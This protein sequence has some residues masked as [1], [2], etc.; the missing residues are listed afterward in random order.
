MPRPAPNAPGRQSG[1]SAVIEAAWLYYHDGRN[2]NEIAG[3]LG[4]SRAT[5]VNYLQ[6]A[7]ERGLVRISL[8]SGAFTTHRLAAD[9][10]ARFG[11]S[12][13]Y[14]VP[15]TGLDTEA[16]FRRVVRG[17]AE[18]LP[19]L[20]AQGQRLG[21]AW[22][23]TMYELAEATARRPV[24][25]LTILQLVGSMATPYGFT[26]EACSTRLAGRL[27]ASCVNLHAPAILSNP[28][29]AAALRAEPIIAE[30]L[31]A[32]E[33]VDRFLFSVGT[34]TPDSHIVGSGVATLDELDWYVAR[35][36]TAVLCGRFI[37]DHG[38]AIP[39]PLDARMIGIEL[40]RMVRPELGLMATPGEDKIAPSRAAMRGG[41]VTHLV[42]SSAVAEALLAD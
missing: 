23:R 38:R 13:A 5:V 16:A 17:A 21:L 1:E 7:R 26:S 2:Q 12:A 39:G 9:L 28:E 8:D 40:S 30:Q 42:T 11:L 20:L 36:A 18:W 32:L 22:G 15:V 19:E 29:L 14:V 4:L 35:G 3:R 37:D 27:G 33:A 24:P 25:E 34:V 41:Y 10:C 6:A 31:A